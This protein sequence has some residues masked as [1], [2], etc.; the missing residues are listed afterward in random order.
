[1]I[2]TENIRSIKGVGD[3]TAE[4]FE[5]VGVSTTEDLIHYYPKG[6]ERFE[7]P[8]PIYKL[9][10]G[11]IGTVE[12]VLSKDA[13]LNSFNGLRIVNAY[14]S[15]MTG[16]LQ[17]SWYNLPYIKGNLKAGAHYVFRGRIAEKNGRLIMQQPKLYVPSEYKN[18]LAGRLCP[19][20]GLTK[21][22]TQA[23][24]RKAV[25]E[26]I[27]NKKEEKEYLPAPLLKRLQM[28]EA[29]RALREIHFPGSEES[30]I[31]A[32]RRLVF[33]E[34]FFFMLMSMRT[35]AQVEGLRS[36]FVTRP[37]PRLL[38]F[39]ASLPYELTRP[40]LEAYKAI[41]KDMSSGRVM[42]RLIQGDVGSGKTIIAVL[43][44]LNAAMS[45]YQSALMAPTEVLAAQHYETVKG[46]IENAG[47]EVSCVLI[48][49]STK[50]SEKRMYYEMAQ[51]H[52]ADII[53]GTH[54]LIREELEFSSLGLVVT[55]EQHR[56]GVRQRE[57]LNAKGGDPHVLVMSATPIPRT[58]ALMLYGDLDISVINS[59]PK[60]RIPIKNCVVGPEY[61]KNAYRFIADEVKKGRQAYVICPRVEAEDEEDEDRIENVLDYT[62]RLRGIF[63]ETVRIRSLHGGMKPS[64]K[65]EIMGSFKAG[66]TDILVSTTVVEVG[67]DVPNATVIMIEN[68]DRFGLA[69]LHQLRGRVGR[70]RAQSYCIM[71]NSSDSEKSKERLEILN[72]TNDGFEIAEADLKLRGPG[73]IFGVRQSGELEF[74]LA[75]IYSDSELLGLAGDMAKRLVAE[76]VELS[77][78]ENRGIKERLGSL[79]ARFSI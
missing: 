9:V 6:Y 24:V 45:G 7:E 36:S 74:K 19:L 58:L 55:D 50:A 43:A 60:G 44:M 27:N 18:L 57:K 40:Q 68:A 69:Q 34:F 29:D 17:L 67:V 65:A 52:E 59:M 39:I 25:K 5:R 33:D 32:R 21:G 1:M 23:A 75:D 30:L 11:S 4:L 51:R 42:N 20:Y 14:I 56:F 13:T 61:R 2:M 16:R 78:P 38:S 12:G 76:D 72:R 10:I 47:L 49:G 70:G 71:I 53:I 77:K 62:E 37:S 31:A 73:D 63:P 46:L 79:Q 8:S 64:E 26:Y 41:V 28:T 48:T 3:K 22:L 66:D 54:A 15:D 35:K